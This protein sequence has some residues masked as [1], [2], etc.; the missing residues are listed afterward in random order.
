MHLLYLI[1][2]FGMNFFLK[3]QT[4]AVKAQPLKLNEKKKKEMDKES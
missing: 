3:N 2:S 4:D 1:C